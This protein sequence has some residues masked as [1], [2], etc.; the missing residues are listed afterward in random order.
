MS[1]K[2]ASICMNIF[3]EFYYKEFSKL[4]KEA[5]E[6][7]NNNLSLI[8]K[9]VAHS[10]QKYPMPILTASQSMLLEGVGE[11]I[12]KKFEEIIFSYREKIE[13]E[14]INYLEFAYETNQ[15][16]NER[17]KGG[18]RKA[19]TDTEQESK[20]R[21]AVAQET[22][23]D[24]KK[25]KKL[26][27]IEMYSSIWS[28]VVCCYILH[29]QTNSLFFEFDDLVAMS[30][31][32][33]DEL[34]SIKNIK[35]SQ[36]KDDFKEMKNLNLLEAVDL[37]EKK[38]KITDFLIKLA[39]IEL[40]KS[41]ILVENDGNGE[42][43]FTIVEE[44]N[45]SDINDLGINRANTYSNI[46]LNTQS[47]IYNNFSNQQSSVN[48]INNFSNFNNFTK[49]NK[50]Y[51]QQNNFRSIPSSY[52]IQKK[53][54][55]PSSLNNSFSQKSSK[56]KKL[57]EIKNTTLD[58]F[59]NSKKKFKEE[60][61]R[62]SFNLLP[63]NQQQEVNEIKL[64]CSNDN[65]TNLNSKIISSGIS[66]FSNKLHLH[67]SDNSTQKY[68]IKT[69]IYSG[70]QSSN[71]NNNFNNLS[72]LSTSSNISV[73]L[74][75]SESSCSNILLKR[76]LDLK[77]SKPNIPKDNIFLIVDNREKGPKGEK[78]P[79]EISKIR[80]DIQVKEGNLAVGDF[81]WTYIDPETGLEFVLDFI[82]ER[83]TIED[84]AKSILDGRYNE[85]KYRLKNC[86]IRNIYYIFEGSSYTLPRGN[87]SKSAIT[88]AIFN[89]LNIHD[90]NIVKSSSIEDS[91]NF[92]IK[93]D[94]IIRKN[95]DSYST[96]ALNPTNDYSQF[97]PEISNKVLLYDFAQSNAKTKYSSIENIFV[98]QLR[99][100]D[101]C[102]AKSVDVLRKVF[103]CPKFIFELISKIECEETKENLITVA[104]YLSENNLEL[105]EE[106]I[107]FYAGPE[108]FR[109][110]K[111]DVKSI[112]KIR[113][114]TNTS[115]VSF[116][117]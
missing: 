51:I 84:L 57:D 93:M 8:Y 110:L 117:S 19:Q 113:K 89:T 18:K 58:A 25:R 15:N 101:D 49:S 56:S 112:K 2:Q 76:L 114:T 116:Y 9:K 6:K 77:K 79:E 12:S 1:N 43:N 85:Q 26:I 59:F 109:F 60:E 24:L 45:C 82:I 46:N 44:G 27:N 97:H 90:I 32:L 20:N 48:N 103:K 72:L 83:K 65:Y 41:G 86:G 13:K 111:K 80:P 69:S 11:T 22:K 28:S 71:Q 67:P 35:V 39:K 54:S 62:F 87:I 99:C 105:T 47:Q 81:M 14:N 17:K 107:I 96:I 100:F 33:S 7:N 53:D 55:L 63:D 31:T 75:V 10:V 73:N 52:P 4:A 92:L 66:N 70:Q 23:S 78:F 34:K 29:L 40:Q 102:G 21:G 74:P 61:T 36:G 64:N 91:V 30:L 38:I 104:S 3:N 88:T 68:N 95:A 50:S 42:L 115:I 98:R 94:D 16:Y 5:K 37:K 108:N 106:N